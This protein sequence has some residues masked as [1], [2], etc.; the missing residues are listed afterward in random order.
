MS[1]IMRTLLRYVSLISTT[2]LLILLLQCDNQNSKTIEVTATAFNSLPEQTHPDHPEIA[3]W[4]DKLEPG[5]KAI[6][7]SR[8]LLNMGLTY[9][10]KVKI[11]GLKGKYT[12]VDKMNKRWTKRIDIYMGKDKEL[13]EE[14][15]RQKV[16]ITWKHND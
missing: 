5:M 12:V 3:A 13:A 16:S 8:D 14:W 15:G 6:A 4:G 1:K 2:L 9:N 7:V 10:T 11:E